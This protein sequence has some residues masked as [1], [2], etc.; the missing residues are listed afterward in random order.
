MLV[1]FSH[2]V[3]PS[4][5]ELSSVTAIQGKRFGFP[6]CL[7]SE[8]Q[9][10]I[11]VF[12]QKRCPARSR[13]VHDALSLVTVLSHDSNSP[14][15]DVFLVSGGGAIYCGGCALDIDGNTTFLNNFS[16]GSGGGGNKRL[17][18]RLGRVP[19]WVRRM[20][21]WP[22]QHCTSANLAAV[23]PLQQNIVL[24]AVGNSEAV[25]IHFM[26]PLLTMYLVAVISLV[27]LLGSP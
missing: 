23:P 10:I 5:F 18:F 27:M 13:L 15:F 26:L 17:S 7:S 11:L 25:D 4:C 2:S 20:G 12:G 3:F 24:D 16:E 1:R 8:T 6:P 19:G 21:R 22:L 9:V 14:A